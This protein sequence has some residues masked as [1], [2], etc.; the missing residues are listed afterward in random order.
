ML[1]G[2]HNYLKVM[3]VVGGCTFL[4]DIST[5]TI[6]VFML[7]MYIFSIAGVESRTPVSGVV[8]RVTTK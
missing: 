5:Y 6:I 8:C 1:V 2:N 3:L 4:W 7:V